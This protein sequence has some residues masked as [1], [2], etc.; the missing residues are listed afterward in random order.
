MFIYP[1]LDSSFIV[2]YHVIMVNKI[3]ALVVVV[4]TLLVFLLTTLPLTRPMANSL[5][6]LYIAITFLGTLYYPVARRSIT[7]KRTLSVYVLII[8]VAVLFWVGVTGWFFSPFF[9]M[10]YLLAI[11]LSFVLSPFA[12]FLFVLTLIGLFSPNIGSIDVVL[13][14]ITVASLFFIVPVTYF[15]QKEY[16]YLREQEK[17]V[18]ILEDEKQKLRNMV[19]EVLKNKVTRFAVN[20]KQPVNDIKQMAIFAQNES[21]DAMATTL[22]KIVHLGEETLAS[23]EDFEEYVTGKKLIHTST[24]KK[25]RQK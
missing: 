22:R 4:L 13:D 24:K 17:K 23:L 3:S 11:I 20:L 14:F 6:M 7:N 5:F 16:L 8:F 18:L 21:R 9:Y 15:L 1:A 19:D 25:S 10:L 12:T 2:D